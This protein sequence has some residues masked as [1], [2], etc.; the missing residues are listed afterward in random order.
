MVLPPQA[1]PSEVASDLATE[2]DPELARY[3]NRNYWAGRASTVDSD[4]FMASFSPS[5]PAF[6]PP[7]NPDYVPSVVDPAV[8]V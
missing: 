3:L 4:S 2:V 5:A 8:G 1:A 7:V 6:P